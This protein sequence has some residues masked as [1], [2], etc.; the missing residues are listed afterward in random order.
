MNKINE[1]TLRKLTTLAEQEGWQ[2][3]QA[4]AFAI[5]R[6]VVAAEQAAEVTAYLQAEKAR[7]KAE[8]ADPE[9]EAIDAE[10][11]MLRE[12]DATYC[13]AAHAAVVA[14]GARWERTVVA[15]Y[16]HTGDASEGVTAWRLHHGDTVVAEVIGEDA[17]DVVD[18]AV[19]LGADLPKPADWSGIEAR[20]AAIRARYAPPGRDYAAEC[21]AW[22][23]EHR[24][25]PAD[26]QRRTWCGLD[27]RVQ[28]QLHVLG[29]TRAERRAF[30]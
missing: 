6:G 4:V 5:R 1:S 10:A 3:Q 9:W 18:T 28:D 2:P 8:A 20:R 29:L 24:T 22:W 7:A 11:T 27:I 13:R 23:A 14:S 16:D 21:E 12:Q 30:I 15:G 25:S 26:V 19:H 17:P